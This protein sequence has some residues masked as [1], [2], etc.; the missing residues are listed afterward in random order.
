[1]VIRFA[2]PKFALTGPVGGTVIGTRIAGVEGGEA[3]GD[4]ATN[5]GA[6]GVGSFEFVVVVDGEGG[7]FGV[8][9]GD[10]LFRQ[11]TTV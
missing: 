8:D 11:G 5:R 1:M 6:G 9:P 4:Y 2:R 10:G 7:G 3:I